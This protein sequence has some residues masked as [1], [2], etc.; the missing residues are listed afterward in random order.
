MRKFLE[1]RLRRSFLGQDEEQDRFVIK[2]R[3]ALAN[4]GRVVHLIF[5]GMDG[6]CICNTKQIGKAFGFTSDN[7]PYDTEAV[8]SSENTIEKLR[9]ELVEAVTRIIISR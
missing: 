2:Q 8:F 3:N 7:H 5:A 4:L 1:D 6:K 9:T